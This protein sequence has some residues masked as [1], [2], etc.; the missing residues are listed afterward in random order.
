MVYSGRSTHAGTIRVKEL[1]KLAEFV[2]KYLLRADVAGII[3]SAAGGD[4]SKFERGCRA[5][6][7][8]IGKFL[9]TDEERYKRLSQGAKGELLDVLASV[10]DKRE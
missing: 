10:Q 9:I 7:A 5:A 6:F 1:S 4:S 3:V 2:K 8:Y